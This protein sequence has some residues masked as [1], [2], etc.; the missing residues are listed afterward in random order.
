MN[1]SKNIVFSQAISIHPIPSVII[2]PNKTPLLR[3]TFIYSSINCTN[4]IQTYVSYF[5]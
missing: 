2:D 5:C 4:S 3:C 1:D